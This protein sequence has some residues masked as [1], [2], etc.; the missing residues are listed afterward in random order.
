MKR[1]K[2]KNAEIYNDL[3]GDI[4]NYPKYT[5]QLLNLANQ[6]SQAT[7][8]KM[9]GQMSDLIQEFSGNTAKEWEKWYLEK[10]PEAIEQASEKIYNMIIEL[11]KAMGAF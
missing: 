9:V 1:F 7:R 11:K 2:I 4:I 3:I 10:Q 5:T 8:P 6:N